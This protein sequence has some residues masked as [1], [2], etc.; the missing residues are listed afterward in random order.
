MASHYFDGLLAFR[1]EFRGIGYL[2]DLFSDLMH[3]PQLCL[4]IHRPYT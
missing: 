3:L 2:E 1:G 4:Y